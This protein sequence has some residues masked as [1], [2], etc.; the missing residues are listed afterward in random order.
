MGKTTRQQRER[1]NRK[2][3]ENQQRTANRRWKYAKI[4]L[5]LYVLSL[6][7]YAIDLI[8]RPEWWNGV[9]LFIMFVGGVAGI[10]WIAKKEI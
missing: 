10:L 8:E 3:V 4:F 1:N 5:A 2:L 6:V 7:P 9:L